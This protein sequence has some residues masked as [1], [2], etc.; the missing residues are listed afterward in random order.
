MNIFSKTTVF[1]EEGNDG[2]VKFLKWLKALKNNDTYRVEVDHHFNFC[3]YF[4]P[5]IISTLGSH[6]NNNGGR[7]CRGQKWF[8]ANV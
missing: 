7:S 3:Y 5:E 8:A 6:H 1:T 2:V 4:T